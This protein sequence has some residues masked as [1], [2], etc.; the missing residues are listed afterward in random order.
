M[1]KGHQ[2]Q[3]GNKHTDYK[4]ILTS[5]QSSKVMWHKVMSLASDQGQVSLLRL[6]GLKKRV[7]SEMGKGRMKWR[8]GEITC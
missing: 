8:E 5:L 7:S 2:E 6:P 3:A 4:H 1:S